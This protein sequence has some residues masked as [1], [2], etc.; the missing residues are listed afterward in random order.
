MRS[1]YC[2][3]DV[4]ARPCTRMALIEFAAGCGLAKADAAGGDVGFEIIFALDW[5][6]GQAAEHGELANVREGVG[7]G[8]LQEAFDGSVERLGGGQIIV[9]FFQGGEE[10]IDFGVP[11]EWR[12]VVPGLLALGDGKRPVEK[13]AHVR[14]DLR[15]G[16]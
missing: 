1:E 4:N 13:V 7:N 16:A 6:A 14:E 10:A 3:F 12:G 5:G 11:G 15:G 8:A 9:E 2:D